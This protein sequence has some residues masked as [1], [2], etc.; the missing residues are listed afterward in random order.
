MYLL[1]TTELSLQFLFLFHPQLQIME[2]IPK[3]T[4]LLPIK[5]DTLWLSMPEEFRTGRMV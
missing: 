1:L 2:E 4:L 5:I 3:Q